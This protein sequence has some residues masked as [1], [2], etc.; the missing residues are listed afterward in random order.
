MADKPSQASEFK[1]QQCGAKLTYAPATSS[2]K[3]GYCDFKNK[4]PKSE[5][6]IKELDFHKHLL[7]MQDDEVTEER[8]L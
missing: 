3:C 2:L 7:K 4:I 8:L 1:C 6:D 5:F